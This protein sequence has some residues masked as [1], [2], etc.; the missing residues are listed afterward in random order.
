MQA[1]HQDLLCPALLHFQITVPYEILKLQGPVLLHHT[2]LEV[3]SSILTRVFVN[4]QLSMEFSSHYL[5]Q[6]A[7]LCC[8]G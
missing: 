8:T 4:C 2:C 5:L 7:D 3:Q 6:R 1:G